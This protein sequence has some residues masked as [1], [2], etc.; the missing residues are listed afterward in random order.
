MMA[1]RTVDNVLELDILTYDGHRMR[2][3]PTSDDAL[4][5]IIG[6]GGRRGIHRP[7]RARPVLPHRLSSAAEAG[8]AAVPVHVPIALVVFSPNLALLF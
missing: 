4:E 8:A 7:I 6:E 5:K 1:G 3:G 2:V